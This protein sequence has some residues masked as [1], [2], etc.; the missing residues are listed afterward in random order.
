[1]PLTW[2]KSM[3]GRWG[4]EESPPKKRRGG[5]L[6]KYPKNLG[7]DIEKMN[8]KRE[9]RKSQMD[10]AAVI[11]VLL[12]SV[13]SATSFSTV[14]AATTTIIPEFQVNTSTGGIYFAPS[15]G[16][17]PDENFVITWDETGGGIYA[18]IFSSNGTKLG[19][20]FQPCG[21]CHQ[22][23]LGV[24]SDGSFVIVWGAEKISGQR[25]SSNGTKLGPVFKVDD[26]QANHLSVGVFPDGV[27]VVVWET[28][29]YPHYIFFS[30]I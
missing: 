23:S 12:F 30:T 8:T 14:S 7:G 22:P 6:Y 4:K 17:F 9:R 24:L 25:F 26:S 5:A 2:C 1:M 13:I 3:R 11:L 18:Q 28:I 20:E 19:G 16:A 27:F 15:V 21:A 29:G 10:S